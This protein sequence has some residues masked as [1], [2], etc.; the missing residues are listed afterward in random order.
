MKQFLITVAGVVVGLVLFL[1]V[2]PMLLIGAISAGSKAPATPSAV[3]LDLDLRRPIADAKGA[4][5]FSS[6]SGK[7]SA[8]EILRKLEAAAKDDKV[9]GV[10]VRANVT[11]TYAAQAEELRTALAKVK[12]AKKFVI[13]HIQNDSLQTSLAGYMTVAGADEI[14]LQDAGDFQPMGIISETMFLG[15]T[16]E[17]FHVV[18]QFEQREEY[19]NA[20]N[21]LT[22]KGYTPAHRQAAQDLVN[23]LY[24]GTITA[25]AADRKMTREQADAAIRGTPYAG[26]AAIAAKLVDKLG[27]PEDSAQAALARAGDGA[28][29]LDI[30][31]YNPP[32]PHGPVIALI[33]GDGDI[34][35]GPPTRSFGG[36]AAMNSDELSEAFADAAKDDDVKAIVFRVNSPG[37]S[38]VASD[39]ILHAV[40]L[41]KAKGK[42]V[43][44]SMANYAAS[45]GYYVS[46]GADSIV[47]LP[48]TIT[49]S[50]GIFGGKFVTG[51]ALDR[52]AGIKSDA[53]TAGSPYVNMFNDARPF[54]NAEREQ[55]KQMIDRGYDSF[56]GVVAKGRNMTPEQAHAVAH[57]RVWTGAQAKERGLVDE[58]G[59]LDVAIARAKQLAKIDADKSVTL[60]LYPKQRS[61]VEELRELFGASEEAARAA[62]F[63]SVFASDDRIS[64][65]VNAAVQGKQG[66]L[67]ARAPSYVVR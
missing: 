51:D 46:A 56:L 7:P 61:P 20:V 54:S 49:G 10:Y 58:L 25:I 48:T 62:A 42:K 23:N 60:K 41:A 1:I 34:L 2:G 15:G 35:S 29:L 53:V 43:V 8:V 14:W 12:A 47:A 30:D 37:G 67:K 18:A 21:Q 27:R 19:K 24:N 66:S 38:A 44:V 13:A 9:K 5:P 26:K 57:G 11:G 22:Q 52:Y 6:L 3:V 17:K 31:D 63:L 28:E 32:R 45:G 40:E 16:L 4:N 50:I 36:D 65:A 39:Q 55:F 33:Q 64:A 59:G